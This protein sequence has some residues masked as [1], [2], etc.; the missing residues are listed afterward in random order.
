MK[1]LNFILLAS[2]FAVSNIVS[3]DFD[4]NEFRVGLG[5]AGVISKQK[6]TMS[7]LGKN[8]TKNKFQPSLDI[9]GEYVRKFN[10]NNTGI[11]LEL[12]FGKLLGKNKS[13][14]VWAKVGSSIPI[15]DEIK[16]NLID[17]GIPESLIPKT[18]QVTSDQTSKST[19]KQLFKTS[20]KASLLQKIYKDYEVFITGGI[21]FARYKFS[22]STSFFGQ[23]R[24]NSM[25]K[26]RISFVAGL[27]LSK[28]F[29]EH[30]FAKLEYNHEFQKSGGKLKNSEL[31]GYK[32]SKNSANIFRVAV[33]YIF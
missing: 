19:I 20:L 33:G 14:N 13:T 12:A 6:V 25:H 1:K 21:K 32:D 31:I 24:N 18:K 27:G 17:N 7:E 15:T 16:A 8:D 5:V 23:T 9:F 30:T 26:N 28:N 3:S 22:S 4:P 2:V 10:N 29:G 11:G